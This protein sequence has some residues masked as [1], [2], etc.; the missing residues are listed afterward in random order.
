ME[1]SALRSHLIDES[2]RLKAAV[3]QAGPTAQVPT[4]PKWTATDLLDH[5]TWSYDHK[6]QCMRLLRAPEHA[7]QL[8]RRGG[9][10]ERFDAALAELLTEFDAR[11]PER[12]AH[13]WYGPDQTVGFWIRRAAVET[14]VCRAEAELAAGRE[15]GPVDPDFALDAIEETLTISFAWSSRAFPHGMGERLEELAGLAVGIDATA[16]AWT[17]R[18]ASEAVDVSEGI[19]DDVRATVAGTPREILMWL[20]RRLPAEAIAV[21][22]ERDAANE[23]YELTELFAQ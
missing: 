21:K 23:L 14:L 12:L 2:G 17:L 5:V 4:M 15:V 18:A 20:W 11:G 22:G 10:F 19:A 1:P 7:E 6:L 3:A 16:G 9:T 8:V 13:T